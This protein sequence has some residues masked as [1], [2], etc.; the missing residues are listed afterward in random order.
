[1]DL[2]VWVIKPACLKMQFN[3][4]LHRD[5]ELTINFRAMQERYIQELEKKSENTRKYGFMH[6]L[7]IVVGNEDEQRYRALYENLARVAKRIA[8]SYLR[9]KEVQEIVG[10]P[11]KAKELLLAGAIACKFVRVGC[12]DRCDRLIDDAGI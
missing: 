8:T 5:E 2:N 1:M 9:D 11:E 10:L 7:P 12:K 3:N 4:L 6:C